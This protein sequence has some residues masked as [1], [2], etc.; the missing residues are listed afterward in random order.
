M[1]AE[2]A[3]RLNFNC[4]AAIRSP[5]EIEHAGHATIDQWQLEAL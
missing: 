5:A 4:E 3:I 1:R 2:P